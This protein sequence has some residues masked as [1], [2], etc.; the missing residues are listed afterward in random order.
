MKSLILAFL[1]QAIPGGFHGS[2]LPWGYG[3]L[4]VG[5]VPKPFDL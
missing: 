2:S 5:P 4:W 1:I 3:V